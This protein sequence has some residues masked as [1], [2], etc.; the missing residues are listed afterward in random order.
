MAFSTSLSPS[1]RTLLK[2]WRR[3]VVQHSD[4]VSR[5]DAR[6]LDLQNVVTTPIQLSDLITVLNI[7]INRA[8]KLVEELPDILEHCTDVPDEWRLTMIGIAQFLVLER[9]ADKSLSL[10]DSVRIINSIQIERASHQSPAKTSLADLINATHGFIRL[11]TLLTNY[12]QENYYW[13]F[14]HIA[15]EDDGIRLS[16]DSG[17]S[18]NITLTEV[19][20]L[21]QSTFDEG[22]D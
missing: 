1:A 2:Y 16:N 6:I 15:L 10:T 3:L 8:I 19:L 14:T 13:S 22:A 17:D 12:W 21:W 20:A 18:I 7:D 9:D 5:T 11:H 4:I